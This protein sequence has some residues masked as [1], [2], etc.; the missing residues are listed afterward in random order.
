MDQIF[1]CGTDFPSAGRG[2]WG[3]AWINFAF[4]SFSR[5]RTSDSNRLIPP[6]VS[7]ELPS[8]QCT[9]ALRGRDTS[10][11]AT[12]IIYPLEIFKTRM[13]RNLSCLVHSSFEWRGS[14]KNPNGTA[15]S[16]ATLNVNRGLS[17]YK[18]R[19]KFPFS[20][21]LLSSNVS[22]EYRKR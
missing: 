9:G 11:A 10:K 6:I 17:F 2:R 19:W 1:Q 15:A 5:S 13:I 7:T 16:G 3:R 8:F 18:Y 4:S 21:A 14:R 12:R 22:P 20:T